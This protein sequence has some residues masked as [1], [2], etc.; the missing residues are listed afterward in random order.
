MS[1]VNDW[2]LLLAIE[3]GKIST[4]ATTTPSHTGQQ[5]P[6]TLVLGDVGGLE[7]A[8]PG[9]TSLGLRLRRVPRVLLQASAN[10]SLEL[11]PYSSQ[12]PS[13]DKAKSYRSLHEVQKRGGLKAHKSVL[14]Y[15]KADQ[16]MPSH[17]RC[18]LATWPHLQAVKQRCPRR[19]C[20]DLIAG[21]GGVEAG[22][23]RRGFRI[24]EHDILHGP[25]FD[26]TQPKVFFTIF[27]RRFAPAN[28]SE[29]CLQ[30]LA[31]PLVR[32]GIARQ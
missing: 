18:S 27:S 21:T 2:A 26:V 16:L 20:L 19:F 11:S 25:A 3:E 31:L 14:R 28:G 32:H 4:K 1:P 6:K 9:H 17:G 7:K 29:L 30:C 15:E 23:R 24:C 13:F 10:P 22:L 12:W 5:P 8:A